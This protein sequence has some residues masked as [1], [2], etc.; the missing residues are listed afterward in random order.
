[1]NLAW[2]R[3]VD[4]HWVVDPPVGG[5]AQLVRKA[6]ESRFGTS[7][8]RYLESLFAPSHADRAAALNEKLEIRGEPYVFF[9]P[10][11][12]GGRL[13]GRWA[14]DLFAEAAQRVHRETGKMTILAQG[15]LYRGPRLEYAGV[16]IAQGLSHEDVVDLMEGATLVVA[17]ASSTSFQALAQGRVVVATSAGGEE[18]ADRV[19][20]WARA[21]IWEPSRPDPASLC[22][23]A[24]RLLND[25]E[26][27]RAI[28]AQVQALGLRNG[29][30]QAIDAM[31]RLL[32]SR[33]N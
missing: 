23:A 21:G 6:S 7:R 30:D 19:R 14:V 1:M 29:L 28:E 11:G 4:E 10:G 12:G 27:F 25:S 17:G 13:G 15:P 3:L 2:R 16:Q 18:Q 20:R 9:V 26:R 31:E 33:L 32:A 22:A 24:A 5:F 8:L